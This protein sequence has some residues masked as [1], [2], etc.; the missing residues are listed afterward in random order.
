MIKLCF[1]GGC[2]VITQLGL[3]SAFTSPLPW[4]PRALQLGLA[5]LIW[6]KN[7]DA[8]RNLSAMLGSSSGRVVKW[9]EVGCNLKKLESND[10]PRLVE[11]MPRSRLCSQADA[12]S[13]RERRRK[14]LFL[15]RIIKFLG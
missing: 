13:C 8:F 14:Y 3:D 1:E 15:V 11:L 6:K 10:E 2:L 9:E 7:A 12:P 4:C 5:W